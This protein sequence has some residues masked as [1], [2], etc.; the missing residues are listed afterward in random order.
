MGN[1]MIFDDIKDVIAA[2]QEFLRP[3]IGRN[4]RKGERQLVVQYF[5]HYFEIDPDEWN[6]HM[7]LSKRRWILFTNKLV[8][9]FV[10]Q[11]RLFD[12]IL[13]RVVLLKAK[14]PNVVFGYKDDG[15]D[16]QSFI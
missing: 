2:S 15:I 11:I 7:A 8:I 4:L 14:D 3:M 5:Y 13:D 12:S 6:Q 16:I 1:E 10:D 9:L